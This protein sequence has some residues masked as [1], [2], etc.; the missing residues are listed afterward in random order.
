M[1]TLI[2]IYTFTAVYDQVFIFA[3]GSLP[4]AHPSAAIWKEV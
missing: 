1:P 4:V 3:I 2:D